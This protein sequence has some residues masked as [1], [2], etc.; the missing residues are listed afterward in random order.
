MR[1][2][3]VII[4]LVALFQPIN[5]LAEDNGALEEPKPDLP[6]L[7]GIFGFVIHERAAHN[8]P[9][10]EVCAGLD[11]DQILSIVYYGLNYGMHDYTKVMAQEIL[12][13]YQKHVSAI[14]DEVWDLNPEAYTIYDHAVCWY[15]CSSCWNHVGEMEFE[16]LSVRNYLLHHTDPLETRVEK[17]GNLLLARQEFSGLHR[18]VKYLATVDPDFARL[19]G[20]YLYEKTG[21]RLREEFAYSHYAEVL[22]LVASQGLDVDDEVASLDEIGSRDDFDLLYYDQDS[23]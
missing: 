16:M 1:T 20:V 22:A 10:N 4:L 18:W 6:S 9:W 14:K 23:P 17:V 2:I 3:A 21:E 12:W 19:V 11:E 7:H 8:A 5:S 13:Q 15:T